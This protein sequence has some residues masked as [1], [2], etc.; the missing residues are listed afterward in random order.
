MC[1]IV[2]IFSTKRKFNSCN[3]ESMLNYISHRGPDDSGIKLF[4]TFDNSNSEVEANLAFGHK[5]LSIIDLSKLGHQPMSDKSGKY[6]ITYNG[7]IFNFKEIK[8]ELIKKGY[9][10]N[11]NTDTE[12]IIYSYIEHGEKCLD[13]FRGFFA[14]CI[15]DIEKQEL[16][17]ARDRLG[18]KPL[19][20]YFDGD[21]FAFASELKSFY[22]IPEIKKIVS[23]DSISEYLS[24][25]Y[26]PSPK[27]IFK[28]IKKLSSGHF[29]KFS[30]ISKTLVVKKYWQPLFE[31]KEKISYDEAKIKT[32][33]LLSDS[34]NIRMISDVPVGVFLSGGIDSSS[35]VALLRENENTKDINTFSVGFNDSKFDERVYAK[36]I[37][38]IFKTN[39]TEFLVEPNLE[40]DLEMIINN[41]DEPFSDPSII[42][43]YYLANRVSDYVKVVLGGDGADEMLSGYKRY[44]I[45]KRNAFLNYFPNSFYDLN[46]KLLSRLDLSLN[47]SK[48]I[49]KL[50]RISESLSGN[51]L[52]TY[53]LRLTGFS[54][55]QKFELF[56]KDF[57]QI[58]KKVWNNDIYDYFETHKNLNNIDSLM[59]I[60]QITHLPEYILTKSDISGM[61]NSIEARAPFI[62]VKF[63]EWINK[64]EPSFKNKGYSKRIL[65][66]ILEETGVPKHI[67][68][69]KK[70]GF[71]PPL[72]GWIKDLD[73]L[74]KKYILD[75]NILDF[76]DKNI[77]KKIYDFNIENKYSFSNHVWILLVLAIW[78]ES[79]KE[80]I[81]IEKI[82]G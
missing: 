47:K 68:H 79:N 32:K 76:F 81:E 71:T 35:I 22:P 52:D 41:Y 65:K 67:I 73:L 46:N 55:K 20:Y 50:S 66:D 31:P 75:S 53:Y 33:E 34:I 51:L 8:E 64:L 21:T 82:D 70:A 14:F 77:R 1:G 45:H 78:L 74:V 28:D 24:L 63:I 57:M 56:N 37:S 54:R 48:G 26:I 40:N 36:E 42:P 49:G 43:T 60:D 6:W 69:R 72:Q 58:T 27:T 10:F 16:F 80:F 13:L 4:N 59:A 15:Y 19:K 23:L 9:S 25:K 44:N 18:S 7:E 5:R 17:L 3:L 12:V 39:H 30:L 38:T 29:I 61:A 11:S 62:D 2:G